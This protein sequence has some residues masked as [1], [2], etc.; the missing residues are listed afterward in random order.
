MFHEGPKISAAQSLYCNRFEDDELTETIDLNTLLVHDLKGSGSFDLQEVNYDSIG[1]LLQAL[2]VPTLLVNRSQRVQFANQAFLELT[3][4][5][6]DFSGESLFALLT[7]PQEASETG[8]IL[9]KVLAERKTEVREGVTELYGTKLWARMH[10][11]PLRV[12]PEQFVLIQIENLTAQKQLQQIQKYKDLISTLPVAVVEFAAPAPLC[13]SLPEESLLKAILESR[14]VDANHES[15]DM[16]NRRSSTELIGTRLVGIMPSANGNMGKL[17]EWIRSG[18]SACVFEAGDPT[19][20]DSRWLEYTLTASIANGDLFGFWCLVRDITTRK[21]REKEMVKTAKLESLGLLAGG[22]AHDFNNLLTGIMGNISFAQK[23]LPSSNKAYE[24]LGAALKAS[25]RAQG[26]TLQ[27]LTF[28]QGG[29]PVKRTASIANLLQETVSFAATGA[30]VRCEFGIP[31]SLWNVD[32]DEGQISLVIGN[33]IINSIQAMPDGGTIRVKAGNAVAD[34][35]QR[36]PLKNGRYVRV[37]IIDTGTGIPQ[38]N[39]QKIFDPYFTTKEKGT[40]LG[41]STS[42][43]V[44]KKHQGLIAVRSELGVGSTF[45]IYLP[46]SSKAV[47]PTGPVPVHPTEGSGKILLMEDEDVIRELG[48]ELLTFLGY[49]VSAARDGTEAVLMFRKAMKSKKPFD[50][51]IMD[52]TVPGGMGGREAIAELLRLDPSVRAVV[53]SGYNNDPVMANYQDYGFIGVLPKPYDVTS[54]AKMLSNLFGR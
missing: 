53:S 36:L 11:R 28:S 6:T 27:L 32:I 43:S 5:G 26:L 24:R 40:G 4:A 51:V 12:G 8:L 9:G 33:L 34:G 38:E 37:S 23:M 45:N 31:E 42:Y 2:P 17:L 19:S 54:A 14:V 20:A 44:V 52:L 16:F 41:L 47:A 21:K 15:L 18:F 48:S 35:N 49:E 39:L 13:C 22:I 1:R 29:A 46:A 10:F 25:V 7:D 30:K 50:L 3:E